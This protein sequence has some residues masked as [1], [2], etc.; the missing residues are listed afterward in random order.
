MNLDGYKTYIVGVGLIMYALGGWVAG[1]VDPTTAIQSVFV[2]LG[3]MGL[4]NG[5]AKK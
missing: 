5:I 2:A 1:K 4:R 3:L